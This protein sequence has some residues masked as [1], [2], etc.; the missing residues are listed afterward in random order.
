MKFYSDQTRIKSLLKQLKSIG[1]A[2]ETSV[3]KHLKVL[4]LRHPVYEMF[5]WVVICVASVF[6]RSPCASCSIGKRNLMPSTVGDGY[7]TQ[8]RNMTPVTNHNIG[9]LNNVFFFFF[10]FVNHQRCTRL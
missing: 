9:F 5:S 4:R 10:F 2:S 6:M 3:S 7:G 1:M 8:L